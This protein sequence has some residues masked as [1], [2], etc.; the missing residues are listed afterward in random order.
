MCWSTA[1]ARH[2]RGPGFNPQYHHHCHHS[3]NRKDRC[4]GRRLIRQSFP[5]PQLHWHTFRYTHGW[6][7]DYMIGSGSEILPHQ[8]SFRAQTV[9]F[10]F[11][12]QQPPWAERRKPSMTNQS[13]LVWIVTSVP[14]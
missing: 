4:G 11:N 8:D 3:Y 1:L 13:N 12:L 7:G 6:V 5:P 10:G 2:L 9:A 14:S